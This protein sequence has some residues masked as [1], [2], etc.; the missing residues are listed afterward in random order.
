[1]ASR[2]HYGIVVGREEAIFHDYILAAVRV[3]GIVVVV[4]MVDYGDVVEYQ[5]MA[6]EVI[7][8]PGCRI[9]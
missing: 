8:H 2:W 5:V 4:G 9:P 3:E 1:M 6:V 7:L